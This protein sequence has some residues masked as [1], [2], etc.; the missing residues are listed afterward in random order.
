[1]HNTTEVAYEM[2]T[3]TKS[4]YLAFCPVTGGTSYHRSLSE[5]LVASARMAS[6]DCNAPRPLVIERLGR[7]FRKV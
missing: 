6:A 3:A 7:S 5:A 2:E 1:M 4:F